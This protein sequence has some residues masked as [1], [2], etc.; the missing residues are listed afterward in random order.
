VFVCRR[1]IA[2]AMDPANGVEVNPPGETGLL[3]MTL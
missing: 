2:L 1:E 3:F